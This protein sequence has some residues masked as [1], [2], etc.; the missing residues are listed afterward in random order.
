LLQSHRFIFTQA[1]RLMQME[2][3]VRYTN[4]FAGKY[5]YQLIL[6][7]FCL[8]EILIFAV[9]IVVQILAIFDDLDIFTDLEIDRELVSEDDYRFVELFDLSPV[10]LNFYRLIELNSNGSYYQINK[11]Y[12]RNGLLSDEKYDN[13]HFIVNEYIVPNGKRKPYKPQ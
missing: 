6:F 3:S 7:S 4:Q 11:F 1:R 13:L 2:K 9:Q 5:H 12:F 10:M 8:I